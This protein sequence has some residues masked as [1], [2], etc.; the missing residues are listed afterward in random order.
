MQPVKPTA[1]A[2]STV[3][4][5]NSQESPV[6]LTAL[7]TMKSMGYGNVSNFGGLEDARER[8]GLPVEKE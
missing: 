2:V 3:A 5:Y 8:L 4:D 1:K 7:N 6:L